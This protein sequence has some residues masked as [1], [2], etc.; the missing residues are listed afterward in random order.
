[1]AY[2]AVCA[3]LQSTLACVVLV[4]MCVCMI[5]C[6]CKFMYFSNSNIFF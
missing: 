4:C 3:L 6:S 2:M 5:E 1:M